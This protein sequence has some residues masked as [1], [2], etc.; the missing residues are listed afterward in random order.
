VDAGRKEGPRLDDPMV[1]VIEKGSELGAHQPG[2]ATPR[3]SGSCSASTWCS[4]RPRATS[5]PPGSRP[6]S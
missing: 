4:S 3:S 2:E 5:R 1:M 6:S